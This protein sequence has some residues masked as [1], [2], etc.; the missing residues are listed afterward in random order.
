[1]AVN[2]EGDRP[3]QG[4]ERWQEG[5]RWH[6]WAILALAAAALALGA[7]GF[8]RYYA[9]QGEARSGHKASRKQP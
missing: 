5:S 4:R 2:W 7:V 1:M 8:S 6:W 3:R 9:L